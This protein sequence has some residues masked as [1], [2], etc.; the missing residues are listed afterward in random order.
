M[1][2][3]RAPGIMSA[4]IAPTYANTDTVKLLQ[5]VQA[6]SSVRVANK[7]TEPG[8]LGANTPTAEC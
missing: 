1:A 7:E 2:W 8:L 6:S 5:L 3:K 4:R